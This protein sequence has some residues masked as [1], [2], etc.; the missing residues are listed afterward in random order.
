MFRLIED[1][2]RG[3]DERPSF[4]TGNEKRD[5]VRGWEGKWEGDR[6]F[7]NQD[8]CVCRIDTARN[9]IQIL[10]TYEVVQCTA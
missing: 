1:V 9:P 2:I 4:W 3:F 5:A 7:P 6:L 10:Y 8:C